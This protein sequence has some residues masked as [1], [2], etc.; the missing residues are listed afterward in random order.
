MVGTSTYVVSIPK[1]WALS[2]EITKGSK[3]SFTELPNRSLVIAPLKTQPRSITLSVDKDAELASRLTI[4]AYLD[5]YDEVTLKASQ[6]EFGSNVR[7]A[8][9]KAVRRLVGFDVLQ[10]GVDLI[11]IATTAEPKVI[12]LENG[13]RRMVLLVRSALDLGFAGVGGPNQSTVA[14]IDEDADRLNFMFGRRLRKGLIDPSSLGELGLDTVGVY[15]AL[16]VFRFLERCVDHAVSASEIY[17]AG[18]KTS[19][20]RMHERFPELASSVSGILGAAVEL[21]ISRDIT[22]TSPVF[23]KRGELREKLLRTSQESR[24]INAPLIGYHLGRVADYSTDIAEI[25]LDEGFGVLR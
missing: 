6:P 11:V 8:I 12:T 13:L 16:M 4:A 17:M 10:E 24:A 23:V 3:V 20:G 25:A 19:K 18:K 7:L 14:E 15:D 2:N 9:R 21:F 5:G 22:R 1:H